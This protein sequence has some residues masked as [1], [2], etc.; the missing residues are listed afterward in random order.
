[1]DEAKPFHLKGNFA[2]VQDEVSAENLEV[3]GAIPSGL[4]G[5]YLRNGA[6]PVTG[7]SEHWFL[8]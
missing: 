3:E 8:G 6:N 2:P 1:M 5:L 4:Q 7:H